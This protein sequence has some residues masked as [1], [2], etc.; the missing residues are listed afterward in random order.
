MPSPSPDTAR[1]DDALDR[2][3]RLRAEAIELRRIAALR[4]RP[5]ALL[6]LATA[7]DNRAN[8]IMSAMKGEGHE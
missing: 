4:W 8:A 1:L 7:Y 3:N 5:W 6:A 2:A